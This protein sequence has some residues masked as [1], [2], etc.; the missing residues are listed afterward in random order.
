M[1]MQKR[2]KRNRKV[3]EIR[4][5]RAERSR[6]RSAGMDRA[7]AWATR[8]ISIWPAST[9]NRYSGD[10]RLAIPS[11]FS[12][13]DNPD[14]TIAFLQ[15]LRN[16][17]GSRGVTS[18]HFDHETCEHTDLCASVLMDVLLM[19]ART[20]WRWTKQRVAIKGMLPPMSSPLHK[21]LVNSG[22]VAHLGGPT[23]LSPHLSEGVQKFK[24]VRGGR[25]APLES[26]RK[27]IVSS[28]LSAYF[29]N[30]MRTVGYQLKQSA[31]VS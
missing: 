3:Q 8:P 13:I 23:V 20:H 6:P 12:M 10:I 5:W 7:V 2:L 19:T 14:G 29:T 17:V 15:K 4:R 21:L 16:V 1:G 27:E 22:I 26:A 28:D 24:L 9:T 18:I 30:C 31:Q 25:T 11:Q